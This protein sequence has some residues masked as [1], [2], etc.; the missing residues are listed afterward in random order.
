MPEK[1]SF[2]VVFCSGADDGHPA[3]DLEV[4]VWRPPTS[5]KFAQI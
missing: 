3:T 1:L 2:T 5:C 4:G